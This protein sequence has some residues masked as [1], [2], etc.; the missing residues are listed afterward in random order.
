[1]PLQ[2]NLPE[3]DKFLD[4]AYLALSAL[5]DAHKPSDKILSIIGRFSD[6]HLRDFRGELGDIDRMPPYR[7]MS[8]AATDKSWAGNFVDDHPFLQRIFR[9]VCIKDVFF[10]TKALP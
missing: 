7:L 5:R 1:M 3:T 8:L 4:A 9:V 6:N 10:E 2:S